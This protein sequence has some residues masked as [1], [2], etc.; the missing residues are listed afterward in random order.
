MPK[1]L[2]FLGNAAGVKRYDYFGHAAQ[3]DRPKLQL[4]AMMEH[5]Q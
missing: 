3:N 4:S 1:A 2:T 5:P